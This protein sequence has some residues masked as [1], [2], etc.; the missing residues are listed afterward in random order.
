MFQQK[1]RVWTPEIQ[2][3]HNESKAGVAHFGAGGLLK[4]A[5]KAANVAREVLPAAEREANLAK[6]LEGSASKNRLY[7]GTKAH[8]DYAEQ[9]GQAFN[10]FTGKPTWLAEEPY[11]ASGYSGGT[12]S[13][14]P[15]HAQI[16]KP[17]VFNFDAN[18][19]AKK[20]FPIAKRFGVDVDHLVSMRKPYSAWE[21][22]NDPAF[23]E[24]VEAAGHDG[25]VINEDGYKTFGV[26][27]PSKIKSAT[28]NR[29]TY[30]PTKPDLNE[31]HGGAIH[32]ARGG[33]PGGAGKRG[34]QVQEMKQREINPI[35]GA[36]KRGADYASNLLDQ[37]PSV[38]DVTS[39][40]VGAIPFVGPDLRKAME[41]STTAVPIGLN[42]ASNM[43]EEGFKYG[44]PAKY[45]K[46]GIETY[47]M[48][49]TDLLDAMKVSDLVG[50]SG[51][52]R[53]AESAGYGEVPDLMD[54]LDAA[55]VGGG[56]Y[57]AAKLG[58]K[59]AK[60]AGKG[61]L[62]VLEQAGTGPRSGSMAAQ[63]GVIKMP[64]G[65]FL[66]G[67][68]EQ[69]LKPLRKTGAEERAYM[70]F[71]R[72]QREAGDDYGNWVT[73]K[74]MKDPSFQKIS[75]IKAA[76]QYLAEK[77]MKPLEIEPQEAALN[78]WVDR[79]LTNYVKKQMA[80]EADPVRKLAEQGIVHMPINEVDT[81]RNHALGIRKMHGSKQ[82]GQSEA[83]KSW[84]DVSDISI[85]PGTVQEIKRVK[86]FG[87]PGADK[88]EPWMEKADPNTVVS[89]TTRNF[90][91]QDLGFDHIVDVLKQDV[92][93]GRIRPEQLNKVSMEQ[94]VRRT[95]EYDQ[96]MAKKMRETQ[97][98]VTEG[99]PVHKEYPEGYKWI[100]L[101][102]PKDL[103]S[104]YK[105]AQN[106][107]NQSYQVLDK[108]GQPLSRME[109]DTP[110]EAV[111]F[112]NSNND[113]R[114]EDA[115][116]Y[117]GDTMG[118]CVGEY[119]PDVAAGRSRIYSL[120]DAKGEPHVTVETKP[121]PH[122]VSTSRRG[123]NFPDL[124][125]FEYGNKYSIPSPYKPTKDQ[126]EQIH[127][128]AYD[129]WSTKGTGRARDVD[130]FYQ[131]AANEILGPMPEE[132]KQIKGKGNRA[133]KEEYLPFVQD[134]VKGGNWR[135]VNEL[136]NAGLR[137]TSDA[138]NQNEIK[139][140]EEAGIQIPK[141][142]T[143][144]EIKDI[145]NKVWPNQWGDTNYASG[146][147]VHM[148]TAGWV[149]D[150]MKAAKTAKAVAEAKSA[151]PAPAVIPN[152]L[153]KST[154]SEIGREERARRQ[155]AGAAEQ[156]RQEL[157][158]QTPVPV[159]YVTHTEKS[160]NPHVGYRYEADQPVGI[161]P[162]PTI[163]V[164][165]LER[166]H[167]GASMLALPWD[168]TNRNVRVSAVS[169]EDLAHPIWSHG[170]IPYSSDEQHLLENIGG[171]SGRL[172][173]NRIVGREENARKENKLLGGTGEILHAVNTMGKGGENYALPSSE[174]AFDVIN[175]RVNNGDLTLKEAD[176]LSNEIRN[177]VDPDTKKQ[178]FKNWAGFI[179][180]DGAMQMYT[181]EGLN[182]PAGDLRKLIADKIIY[183]KKKQE[184][185]N[186]NAEDFV[187]SITHDPLK[188]VGR[189]YIGSNLLSNVETSP[190]KLSKTADFPWLNPYDTNFSATHLGQLEDLVPIQ[191]VMSRRINPIEQEFL[192]KQAAK[193]NGKP[194]TP[195]SL[196]G[197]AISAL[198]KRK[199][200]VA[201]FMD[202]QFF[203]DLSDYMEAL[204]TPLEKKKGGLARAKKPKKVARHG[205]TVS[206]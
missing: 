126:L 103:P 91:T 30:D 200:N 118:H 43:P 101:T 141:Y 193:V 201:Q 183:K 66:T 111:S 110:D 99:M 48:P 100:E 60:M 173:A 24:A 54:V 53:A 64:G 65:N 204:K 190:M 166:A 113:N 8:D 184:L 179:S 5:A 198:E 124:T 59:G 26:F 142:A 50:T 37:G 2:Q 174:F 144:E 151:L 61:A 38:R 73:D 21:V 161:V 152:L 120:R 14:Y 6:M 114:L 12:G 29:G 96:E 191:A 19:E 10:Q 55:Q 71:V 154:A 202:D 1:L 203:Q 148:S 52:S 133:P 196:Q 192:A 167:K 205:N 206:N 80:T 15:V 17:L 143:Q 170:G 115:L 25:Y 187:N 86:E 45:K 128:R 188:G 186:F 199:D 119:C 140:I 177:Y 20:A 27:D 42:M 58:A 7:H 189:G 69:A 47:K 106:E 105:V 160:P 31:A 134:F 162:S 153:K 82:I 156:A 147:E 157:A 13:M 175:R 36:V 180:R 75:G 68:V 11:T 158:K 145:G 150:A 89:R 90:N 138:F 85:Y 164:G 77:G 139:K 40:L 194:Y 3:A 87:G 109:F 163:D 121:V 23:V 74:V 125:G 49:T 92:A 102:A 22:I 171:A 149:N 108:N 63:R 197:S 146:G 97:A 172:I 81:N 137:P 155:A 56:L 51:L 34:K 178:P 9:A 18:D 165:D 57:G 88:Y 4:A 176:D 131:Q 132:I 72:Q 116:K 135:D 130:D 35:A 123:D 129:L 98:K 62:K 44:E 33:D 169:G 28:G 78:N 79:N 16:K 182:G 39:N 95:Y 168:A 195:E 93:E 32:M 67:S 41:G 94:A 122:P 159:G 112:F 107:V 117:E 127:T 104:G 46:A 185:L 83:A 136:R 84:E 76:N 70:D 181:G